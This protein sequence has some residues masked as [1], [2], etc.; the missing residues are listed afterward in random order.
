MTEQE[1]RTL[2][3]D[4]IAKAGVGAVP[5]HGTANLS[6]GASATA[7]APQYG[8][9]RAQPMHSS[10]ALFMLPPAEG[11][12]VIEPGVACNHCGYCKSYGH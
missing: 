3:R 5:V 1:L 2:I 6:A 8:M 7:Q 4:A 10:H 12:C 11:R 9:A